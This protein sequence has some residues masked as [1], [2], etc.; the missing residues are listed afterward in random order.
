MAVAFWG[1][2]VIILFPRAVEPNGQKPSCLSLLGSFDSLAPFGLHSCSLPR[3][4]LRRSVVPTWV[5]RGLIKCFSHILKLLQRHADNLV[6]VVI[7]VGRQAADEGNAGASAA[8]VLPSIYVF[9][10][11]GWKVFAGRR[12]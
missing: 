8:I 11:P 4:C 3:A 9:G 5:I 12:L 7:A 10:C 1:K 2:K 6:H